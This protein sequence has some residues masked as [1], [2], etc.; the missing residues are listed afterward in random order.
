[1]RVTKYEHACLV[2][3][4]EGQR[5]II[6][7]G[8][9][10]APLADVR[11]VVAVA[12]T[13]EHADHWTPEQ[14]QRI[15]D[16]N[17][18]VRILAPASVAPSIEAVVAEAVH[19]GDVVEVGPF[20]LAFHGIRHAVIHSSIPV[21]ENVGVLVN[22]TLFHPGDAFTVPP[23]PVDTLAVPASAPWLKIAEV[24]DYVA[25]VRPR[26]TIPIHETLLSPVGRDLNYGRIQAVTEAGGGTFTP[27]EPGESLDL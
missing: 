21:I 26:R 16:G 20:R 1:M 18:G 24:M 5:L 25:Q 22:D 12:I 8:G 15:V 7:P 3:E 19:D 27:L 23:V 10:T 11:G 17:P 9:F 4:A 2:I 14:L 6:D 13:H